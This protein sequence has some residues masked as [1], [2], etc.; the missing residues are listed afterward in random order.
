MSPDL[1]GRTIVRVVPM[2]ESTLRSLGSSGPADRTR[3]VLVLDDGY[4][5]VAMRDAEGNGVGV[6]Y[7]WGADAEREDI[8][9]AEPWQGAGR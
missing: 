5:L 3:V 1:T 2:A 4:Q 9:T 6:L 8:V 7:G